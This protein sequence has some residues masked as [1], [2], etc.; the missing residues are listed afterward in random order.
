MVASKDFDNSAAP[1]RTGASVIVLRPDAVL[2]V[3]RARP[4][5]EGRWSF[6]GGRSEPGEDAEATAR[7]ELREETALSVGRLVSLGAFRP[8]P[9]TSTLQL[10]VFAARAQSGEPRAGDDAARAEFVPL[11]KVLTLPLTPGAPNWIARAILALAQP[12]VL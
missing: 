9:E 1:A 6:P 7:R 12:P 5:L 4:P 10:T 8:V 11:A 3:L 2:L